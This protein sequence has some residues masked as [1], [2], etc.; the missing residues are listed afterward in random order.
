MKEDDMKYYILE[1]EGIR[2]VEIWEVDNGDYDFVMK[3]DNLAEAMKW[4]G[5]DNYEIAYPALP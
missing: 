3:C 5:D 1:I 4:C 2:Q